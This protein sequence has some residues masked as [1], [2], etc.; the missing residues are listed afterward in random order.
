MITVGIYVDGP[1]IEMGLQNA[2]ENVMLNSVGSVLVDYASS[3]GTLTEAN[4]FIDE[5]YQFFSYQTKEDYE[6]HGFRFIESKSFRHLDRGTGNFSFGKSLT[7]PTLISA[8]VDRLHHQNCPDIFIVVSG[9]RDMSVI[10]DYIKS[11][12]KIAHVL[13][14]AHSLSNYLIERCDDLGFS[15][16]V[17]QLIARTS[18]VLKPHKLST[19][20]RAEIYK[21]RLIHSD[22]QEGGP[23]KVA[24]LDQII[25]LRSDEMNPNNHA[26]W[27]IR[28]FE[29]RPDDWKERLDKE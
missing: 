19:P 3:L 22:Y 28:G 2:G 16:H 20:S 7:D 25:D 8:V 1:N 10:L 26:Y 11:H 23:L 13:G 27:Q 15:C 17:F 9:D 5:D 18:G 29:K 4:L 6:N 21:E 24:H 12:G 14:G